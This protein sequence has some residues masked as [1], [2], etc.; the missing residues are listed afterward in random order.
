MGQVR[1]SP[2]E[3][4]REPGLVQDFD[5]LFFELVRI[6]VAVP[7]PP[8][9]QGPDRLAGG[10]AGCLARPNPPATKLLHQ[11]AEPARRIVDLLALLVTACEEGIEQ[12]CR[13]RGGLRDQTVDRPSDAL[14]ALH[15]GETLA[16]ADEPAGPKRRFHRPLERIS[17][18]ARSP[19]LL[20][21]GIG[22]GA[23]L[24]Q[25]VDERPWHPSC[26]ASRVVVGA[27]STAT[28]R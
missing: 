3:P 22:S 21:H 14:E 26:G 2:L 7:L 19:G 4:G 8:A 12:I 11:L 27:S 24:Y 28:P 1:P 16:I 5:E 6:A 18:C 23:V 25:N 17:T 13:P 10:R 15:E 20:R 9:K